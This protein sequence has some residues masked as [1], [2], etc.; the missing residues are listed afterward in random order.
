[1]SISFFSECVHV[2]T[3][4][5]F[6]LFDLSAISND[7]HVI[8]R[9]GATTMLH[10]AHL[11]FVSNQWMLLN[12]QIQLYVIDVLIYLRIKV[13]SYMTGLHLHSLRSGGSAI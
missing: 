11:V 6:I 2:P 10:R 9:I 13:M 12:D 7:F 5:N 4:D 3:S 1:M 8:L